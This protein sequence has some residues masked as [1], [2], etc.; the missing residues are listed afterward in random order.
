MKKRTLIPHLVALGFVFSPVVH[1]D[2]HSAAPATAPAAEANTKS[3][4]ES[5]CDCKKWKHGKKSK[6]CKNCNTHRHKQ[7]AGEKPAEA[8]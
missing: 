6:K 3:D 8:H 1:A 4:C 5:E 7:E 2:E